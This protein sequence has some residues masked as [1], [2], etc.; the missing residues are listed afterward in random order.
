MA[1][2]VVVKGLTFL[3][4]ETSERRW[5]DETTNYLV[6]LGTAINDITSV[7]DIPLLSI[8]INNNQTTLINVDNL[9]FE[10][11][12]VRHAIIEYS[13]YRVTSSEEVS[14][15]GNLLITYKNNAATWELI[16]NTVGDAGVSFTITTAGQV[17]YTSTNMAGTGYQ[18]KMSFRARAFPI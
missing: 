7:G 17:Q 10:T 4:P 16:D 14:Q 3:I 8:P 2:P 6:T 13:V 12:Q 15:C 18:S 1:I 5:G 11:T 9:S